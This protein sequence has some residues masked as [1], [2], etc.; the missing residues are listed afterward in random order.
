MNN[1]TDRLLFL[2]GWRGLA[3]TTVLLGHFSPLPDVLGSFG[4]ELFFVL[5]GRLMAHILFVE[6]MPLPK[7]F[8]RRFARIYPALLVFVLAMAALTIVATALGVERG[9]DPASAVGALTFTINYFP[10]SGIEVA[11]TLEHIWSLAI[12]E[13]SYALL[14]LLAL[15][16]VPRLVVPVC[17]GLGILGI[18]NGLR[19]YLN[20][21]GDVHEIYW[22]TDVRLAPIFLS[23]G[24]YLLTRNLK[25]RWIGA[26]A[27]AASLPLFF[28]LPLQF[29]FIVPTILLAVAVNTIDAAPRRL[30]SALSMPALVW[31]GTI[32]YSLYLWQQL[33]YK[34]VGGMLMVVPAVATATLSWRFVEVPARKAINSWR[35]SLKQQSQNA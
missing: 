15:L 24:I 32:S 30:L 5:S 8:Q 17:L 11:G 1:Q 23:A 6:K 20:G 16:A 7:F 22:R 29:K 26:V 18:L 31:L 28:V 9:I 13:H 3:I 33:Y 2:D 19:L 12:E 10:V 14:A 25:A 27:L 4:V 21:A 35:F 34:M